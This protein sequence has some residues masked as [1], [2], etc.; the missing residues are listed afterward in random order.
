MRPGMRSRARPRNESWPRMRPGSKLRSRMRPRSELR[1]RMRR[2]SKLRS[3]MRPKTG[4]GAHPQRM[5]DGALLEVRSVVLAVLSGDLPIR[6]NVLKPRRKFSCRPIPQVAIPGLGEG[7]RRRSP[8]HRPLEDPWASRSG[9]GR[10]AP[11]AGVAQRRILARDLLVLNLRR[12]RSDVLLAGEGSSMRST[13]FHLAMRSDREKEPTFNY[14][15]YGRTQRSA[16]CVVK[17]DRDPG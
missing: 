5:R 15:G 2:G 10:G 14:R 1:P 13:S 17:A 3:R 16:R 7:R 6:P 8:R 12:S 4:R 11:V 9:D